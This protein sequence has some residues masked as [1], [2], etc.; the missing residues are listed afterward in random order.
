MTNAATTAR[1]LVRTPGPKLEELFRRLPAG[2]IPVGDSTGTLLIA[3][4]SPVAPAAAR[5]ARLI[6]W[7]GKVFDPDTGTLHNKVGP[8][9]M[10]AVT[11]AVY[12]GPSRLDTN[13]AII[14]DYSGTSVVARRIRDEIRE[15][16]PGVFLG[17]AYWG[18]RLILKFVLD[19]TARK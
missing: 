8:L 12:Y 5:L 14:L 6:A 17:L 4:G 3:P 7:Q 9:G 16:A 10:P 1:E 19:F 2:R 13:Q 15:V 11:A 18:K